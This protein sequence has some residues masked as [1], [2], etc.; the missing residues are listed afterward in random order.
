LDIDRYHR[1]L[2]DVLFICTT[3]LL[4]LYLANFAKAFHDE[5]I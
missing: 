3:D 1:R 4:G 5:S 2:S